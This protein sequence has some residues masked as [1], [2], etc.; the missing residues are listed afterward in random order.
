M[1]RSGALAGY[2]ADLAVTGLT[3]NPTILSHAMA[4]SADYDGSL[5]AQ[6]SEGVA[7]PQDLVYAAALGDL[8]EAASLFRAAWEATQGA[9]GYVSIEV[10][11]DLA[12]DVPATMASSTRSP[13]RPSA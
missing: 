4:A 7:D 2:V 1:L 9:D 6:L 10:P 12:Y 5:R 11:P 8:A 13:P 3:S